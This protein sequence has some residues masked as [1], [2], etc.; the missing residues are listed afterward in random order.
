MCLSKFLV[1]NS[2]SAVT[3]EVIQGHALEVVDPGHAR[4]VVRREQGQGQ[5]VGKREGKTGEKVEA[6]TG[7]FPQDEY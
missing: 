7:S 4:G 6:G 5:G 3:E 2:V 1:C